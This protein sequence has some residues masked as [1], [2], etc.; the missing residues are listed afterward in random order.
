MNIQQVYIRRNRLLEVS[1]YV[2]VL[3][4]FE[5]FATL[6]LAQPSRPP[7]EQ[8]FSDI[9]ESIFEM[10]REITRS[11][12]LLITDVTN[13][14]GINTKG[15]GIGGVIGGTLNLLSV[16]T[17]IVTGVA[18]HIIGGGDLFGGLIPVLG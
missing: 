6:C 1:R 16:G 18:S 4:V 2:I 5:L 10:V 17:D 7:N 3:V 9:L 8:Q 14:L 11:V 12:T 13:A 15:G